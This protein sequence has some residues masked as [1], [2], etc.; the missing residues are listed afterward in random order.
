MSDREGV[1][2]QGS[3]DGG[4]DRVHAARG[5]AWGGL[6]SAAGAVTGLVVTPLIIRSFGLE[7]L[8]LW[9]A[10]GGLAHAAGGVFL[11]KGQK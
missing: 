8:G 10:P 11:G 3:P 7:G 9:A 1:G 5:V 4:T 6:E 2:A